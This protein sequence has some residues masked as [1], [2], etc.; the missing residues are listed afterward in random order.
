MLTTGY[1]KIGTDIDISLG[2]ENG[3][4][5]VFNINITGLTDYVVIFFEQE[6][7]VDIYE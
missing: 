3:S 2:L 5:I 4:A 6:F 7:D 1:A